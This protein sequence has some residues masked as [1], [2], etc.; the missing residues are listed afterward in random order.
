MSSL[1]IFKKSCYLIFSQIILQLIQQTDT[2]QNTKIWRC[3]L[4]NI[5]HIIAKFKYVIHDTFT[6]FADT[7]R[8]NRNIWDRTR[9]T[10]LTVPQPYLLSF[11]A[12]TSSKLTYTTAISKGKF[13]GY[14]SE[15]KAHWTK[16][17]DRFSLFSVYFTLIPF[18]FES[19]TQL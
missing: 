8:R 9:D 10:Y 4:V 11:L 7:K 3:V 1:N 2:N 18:L 5:L 14:I 13:K 15:I 6:M 19:P 12:S 17:R 16:G